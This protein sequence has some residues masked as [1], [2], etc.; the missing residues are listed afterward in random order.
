M[1]FELDTAPDACEA[2]L[3]SVP[4]SRLLS[5]LLSFPLP[6]EGDEDRLKL[7]D[8]PPPKPRLPNVLSN[9][10]TGVIGR[11]GV[12][13]SDPTRAEMGR[14]GGST[15]EAVDD[16]GSDVGGVGGA[17]IAVLLLLLV[18]PAPA[19]SVVAFFEVE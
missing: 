4:S 14:P 10:L 8:I 6:L 12:L 16:D 15:N 18:E 13:L 11:P 17:T 9:S 7:K 5:G 1:T 3:S 19:L 2:V